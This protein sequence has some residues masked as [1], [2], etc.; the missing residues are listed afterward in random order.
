[1]AN[2]NARIELDLEGVDDD[3]KDLAKEEIREFIIDSTLEEISKGRSPVDGEGT[4]QKLNKEYAQEK[5]GGDR[6]PNLELTGQ[7]LDDYERGFKVNSDDS[8]SFSM[9]GF[10]GDKADGH[11]HLS[12]KPSK[13]PR[14]RFIPG[15]GQ[16]YNKKITSGIKKIERSYKNQTKES[17][18]TR[19]TSTQ[20]FG[21]G[22]ED[23]P[24]PT[25]SRTFTLRDVFGEQGES[26]ID[27]V[28]RR[29]RNG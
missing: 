27:R 28:A 23:L 17:T 5:K 18:N 13:L 15:D 8:I 7:M 9:S 12:G 22:E 29:L 14:R 19:T 1:M 16:K 24:E 3:L 6:T 21:Q 26:I 2:L 25:I 11:S 20:G 10:S 4:W